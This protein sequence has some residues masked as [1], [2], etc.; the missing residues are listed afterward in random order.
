MASFIFILCTNLSWNFPSRSLGCPVLLIIYYNTMIGDIIP[1]LVV[2]TIPTFKMPFVCTKCTNP[3]C[4]NTK[5]KQKKAGKTLNSSCVWTHRRFSV[6][7]IKYIMFKS[8]PTN[9][10]TCPHCM[11][12]GDWVQDSPCSK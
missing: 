11:W 10:P 8:M 3:A 4:K 9:A 6:H 5:Q 7:D 12:L 2:H 1:I